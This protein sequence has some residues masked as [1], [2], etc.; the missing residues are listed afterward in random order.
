METFGARWNVQQEHPSEKEGF[1]GLDE[2]FQAAADF[3]RKNTSDELASYRHEEFEEL[4]KEYL[5]GRGKK[6]TVVANGTTPGQAVRFC[7]SSICAT[8]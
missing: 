7:S 6:R 3:E 8:G 1:Y 2:D 4:P 5:Q